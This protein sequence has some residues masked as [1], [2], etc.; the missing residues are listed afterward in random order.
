MGNLLD[1]PTDGEF[2]QLFDSWDVT[3]EKKNINGIL[4]MNRMNIYHAIKNIKKHT[5]TIPTHEPI[6]C[7]AFFLGSSHHWH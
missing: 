7:H 4:L 2:Q 5:F 6:H 3:I 1:H